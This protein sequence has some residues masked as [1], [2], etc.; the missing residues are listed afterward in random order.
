MDHSEIEG[1]KPKIYI[2]TYGCTS[3]QAD[4]DIMR[5]L[6]K[7]YFALSNFENCDIA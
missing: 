1:I 4:S 5:G 3:N 7:R 6:V 2:E